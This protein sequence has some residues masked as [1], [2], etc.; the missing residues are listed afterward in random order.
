MRSALAGAGSSG[1]VWRRRRFFLVI[2][3]IRFRRENEAL[4]QSIARLQR[5]MNGVETA[6]DDGNAAAPLLENGQALNELQD[7]DK[8]YPARGTLLFTCLERH[9]IAGPLFMG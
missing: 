3:S 9:G 4:R 7:V 1:P 2:P 5:A 8:H 6:D